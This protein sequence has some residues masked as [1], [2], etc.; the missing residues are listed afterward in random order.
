MRIIYFILLFILCSPSLLL[1][2]K[3]TLFE[4]HF[5]KLEKGTP[6]TPWST[7]INVDG[8]EAIQAGLLDSD[9]WFGQTLYQAGGA[10]A[11]EPYF[12]P[13][14]GDMIPGYLRTPACN[15]A[16]SSE[17][18]TLSVLARTPKGERNLIL[19][20]HY[21]RTARGDEFVGVLMLFREDSEE[22]DPSVDE[23]WRTFIAKDIEA[24]DSSFF[25]FAPFDDY[26]LLDDIVV[27][28]DVA[29]AIISSRQDDAYKVFVQP[30][31]LQLTLDRPTEVRLFT[32]QGV[33]LF[34][35]ATGKTE[36]IIPLTQ[37][38]IF[39]LQVGNTLKKIVTTH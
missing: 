34:H 2:Q 21:R 14:F 39:L 26:L 28:S 30:N 32:E 36:L 9:Q 16:V 24:T 6:D 35:E 4:E 13:Y 8:T 38:K 20:D 17:K 37:G 12:E 10:I 3:T 31:Q 27:Y 33:C 15:Y 5:D 25:E 29:T 19:A 11:I 7:S 1:A 22:E 18:V 23:T